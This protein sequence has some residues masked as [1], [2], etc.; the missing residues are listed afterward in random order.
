[1]SRKKKKLIDAVQYFFLSQQN[2][3][4]P[5]SV[6]CIPIHFPG[7]FNPVNFLVI[8]WEIFRRVAA[9]SFWDN[10]ILMPALDSDF[11]FF[12]RFHFYSFLNC[13][14]VYKDCRIP[15]FLLP[16]K[17]AEIPARRFVV[18]IYPF[19]I[20]IFPPALGFMENGEVAIFF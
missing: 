18:V 3:M 8:P 9:S 2:S 15:F 16:I 1:V 11:D 13:L 20:V 5:N 4:R 17:A 6:F 10:H 14:P 7:R 19:Q 12:A